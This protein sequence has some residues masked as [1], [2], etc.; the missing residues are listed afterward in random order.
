M[1]VSLSADTGPGRALSAGARCDARCFGLWRGPA[2]ARGS[3]EAISIDTGVCVCADL[4]V[5]DWR[6]GTARRSVPQPASHVTEVLRPSSSLTRRSH[7]VRVAVTRRGRAFPDP[8]PSGPGTCDS[9]A[10]RATRRG[11]A[12]RT[13]EPRKRTVALANIKRTDSR[14]LWKGLQLSIMVQ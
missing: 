9:D 8:R 12:N 11:A 2:A 1:W 13:P 14:K 5:R 6:S 10:A 4:C 7:G 3:L